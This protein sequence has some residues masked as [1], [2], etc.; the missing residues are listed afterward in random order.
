MPIASFDDSLRLVADIGGTNARFALLRGAYGVLEKERTLVTASYPGIDAAIEDYLCQVEAEMPLEAAIAI[1]NPITG[2]TVKMSNSPWS[3][4]IEEV[5]RKLGLGRLLLLNDFTALAMAL[6]AI[7]AAQ[8]QQV[9]GGAAAPDSPLALIGAGTGLGVSALIPYKNEWIP[10]SSEGGHV[11][12]CAT[13]DR[14]AA[15][16]AATRLTHPHVSAER[17]LSGMGLENLYRAVVRLESATLESLSAAQITERGLKG[18]DR[19]CCEALDTF[20]AMLGSIAGNLALTI[21]A[22]GGLYIG[23]GIVPRLGDYFARSRF[24]ECFEAKGRFESYVAAIPTFTIHASNPALLGAA[25]S[26]GVMPARPGSRA[27][28]EP[29]HQNRYGMLKEHP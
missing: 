7:P 9:G 11:S 4:S 8:L 6:P 16:I 1:A 12:L 22:R 14:E 18:E 5:R 19:F 3:F 17:L 24:R 27:A 23:G 25:M 13:S 10:L 15:I 21:G 20:C 26:L 28:D 2:D 29:D